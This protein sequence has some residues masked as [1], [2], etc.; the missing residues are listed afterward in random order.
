VLVAIFVAFVVPFCYLSIIAT[1]AWG[2]RTGDPARRPGQQMRNGHTS[3]RA[4]S[5]GFRS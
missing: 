5:F 4:L 3:V 1:A 2:R